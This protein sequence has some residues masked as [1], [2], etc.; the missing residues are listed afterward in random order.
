MSGSVTITKDEYLR[1][2]LAEEKLCLLEAGGVD[3]WQG[4]SESLYPPWVED[5]EKLDAIQ[6]RVTA[7]VEKM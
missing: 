3:N 5:S 2:R 1:L 6:K 4:Y 7:E